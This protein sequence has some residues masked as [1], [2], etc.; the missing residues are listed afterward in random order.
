MN[1]IRLKFRDG[2]QGVFIP[3][4]VAGK[5]G[6]GSKELRRKSDQSCEEA[7]LLAFGCLPLVKELRSGPLATCSS[8]SAT[9]DV[10]VLS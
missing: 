1:S 2:V 8:T 7:R 6:M 3:Q 5:E 4:G 9:A 10:T